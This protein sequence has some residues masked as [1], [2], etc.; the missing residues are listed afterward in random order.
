MNQIKKLCVYCGA[1]A[2]S[3]YRYTEA[4]QQ[5]AALFLNSDIGLVYGGGKVGLMGILADAVLGN[6][7]EVI[8][9]MPECLV[10]KEIAHSGITKL[11]IV[12]S[13]HERK[14]LISDLADGFILLPGGSGSLD[15]FFEIVTWAQLGFHA[16]PCGILNVANYYDDLLKFLDNAVNKNFMKP[17][18]RDMI[19]VENKPND[20]L[21]RF[22]NYLPPKEY[23][24]GH[25]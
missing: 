3:D 10:E 22:T 20:L 16:K 21:Q 1:S 9:V 6:G 25:K 17:I 19:I 18:F 11:H 2:G 15:E 24:W 4:A 5:L 23:R 14:L 7:G 8:G 12:A 13:M